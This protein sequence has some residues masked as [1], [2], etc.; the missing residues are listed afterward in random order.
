MPREILT[1]ATYFK[2]NPLRMVTHQ[3]N[4]FYAVTCTNYRTIMI[5]I[6]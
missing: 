1:L 4:T 3:N 2:Y 5:R 6:H